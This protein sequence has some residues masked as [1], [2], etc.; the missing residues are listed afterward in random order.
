MSADEET[1]VLLAQLR[2]EV[3]QLR[4]EVTK[5]RNMLF[6]LAAFTNNLPD[7]CSIT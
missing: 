4:A 3:I 6:T 2:S 5:L 7:I 1:E